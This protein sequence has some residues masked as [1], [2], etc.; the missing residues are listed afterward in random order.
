[1]GAVRSSEGWRWGWQPAA[2]RWRATS[3]ALRRSPA[4]ADGTDETERTKYWRLSDEVIGSCI[5]VH[6]HLG[7]GLL[8]SAYQQ[9]LCQELSLRGLRFE[10]EQEVPVAYKG[11]S[12][13]Y[14][15]RIDLI[16]ENKLLVEL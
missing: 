4:M 10:R 16:V 3:V 1:M 11:I 14:G 13:D 2:L 15:Y 5:E 9:C 8:E 7:P 6:R 12:L